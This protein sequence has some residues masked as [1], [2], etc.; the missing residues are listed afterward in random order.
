LLVPD[1]ILA[2][3]R[4]K[5]FRSWILSK[6]GSKF[7]FRSTISFSSGKHGVFVYS[8]AKTSA[9]IIDKLKPPGDY[10]IFFAIIEKPEEV[11]QLK[12][13]WLYFAENGTT[14]SGK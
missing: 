8:P 3:D 7:G 6:F 11:K 12:K 10:K 1:S 5:P 13:E 4:D 14:K 2:C 9:I